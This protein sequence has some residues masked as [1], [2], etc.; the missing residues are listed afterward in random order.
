LPFGEG[1]VAPEAFVDNER[2]LRLLDPATEGK[3][4]LIRLQDRMD[5]DRSTDGYLRGRRDSHQVAG[6]DPIV[7][8]SEVVV[9]PKVYGDLPSDGSDYRPVPWAEAK[10]EYGAL[11]VAEGRSYTGMSVLC[12]SEPLHLWQLCLKLFPSFSGENVEQVAVTPHGE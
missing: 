5:K 12:R 10:Q 3:E 4:R 11:L 1:F 7:L 6:P 8:P 9:F 2:R